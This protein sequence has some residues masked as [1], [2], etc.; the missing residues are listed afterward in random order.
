MTVEPKK[1]EL[2]A[3]VLVR[4]IQCWRMKKDRKYK[5]E[6]VKEMIKFSIKRKIEYK[7]SHV[8]VASRKIQKIAKWLSL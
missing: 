7:L 2:I 4:A 8:W 5:K 1:Y 6:I 3:K